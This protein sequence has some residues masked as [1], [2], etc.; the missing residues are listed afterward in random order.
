MLRSLLRFALLALVGSSTGALAFDFEDVARHA[1]DA[2]AREYVP[3]PPAPRLD[4]E[5]FRDI[6]F[7]SSRASWRGESLPFELQFFLA[8]R[9][10]PVRLHEIVDGEAREIPFS[11]GDF[12]L[13]RNAASG[14]VRSA[15]GFAGFRAHY[16]L[17]APAYKDELIA[18]LGASYFRALGR[19][20][21]YGLSARGLAID[22]IGA[23][24]E[25]FPRFTAFWIAR[26]RPGDDRLVVLAELDSPSVAGAYRFVVRPGDETIVDVQARLFLRQG[27]AT[28]GIA[29]LTSMFLHGENQPRGGDFRPEVHDSD[30]L[31][32]RQSGEWLWRPLVNPRAPLAS[33][34]RTRQLGGFGLMQRDRDF[35]SY[36][37][38]EARYELRPSAWVEPVG[39]WGAGRVELVQLPIVEEYHDNIVAY[40]V[41]ERAPAPG[42]PFD[43]AYR[44]HWQ[45]ARDTRPPGAW[46]VQSRAG[47]GPLPT[48][49]VPDD[50]QLVVDFA[51]PSLESLAADAAVE[52]VVTVDPHT[53]LVEKNAF[54]LDANGR[55]RMTLRA[56]RD[57]DRRPAELRA[58]LR[59]P[60]HTLTETWTYLKP[61]D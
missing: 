54:R 9:E 36:E 13:G 17:N 14:A 61:P 53:R 60:D 46:V 28:L 34:F 7:D 20:Q 31:L 42:Q 48:G 18:F 27:V 2:A 12:N 5:S 35:G 22:T 41:P 59:T 33:S 49:V 21:R 37:D 10:A 55:W 3:P 16:P 29:P 47:H 30:G 32:V 4:Y 38:G 50:F 8:A 15:R 44:I 24:T 58:F 40:W 56:R 26:P 52:P 45:R 6:R 1:R 11:L 25:E 51:G 23:G 19:G 43:I 57:D 39:D